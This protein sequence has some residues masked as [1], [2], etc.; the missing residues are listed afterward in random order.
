MAEILGSNRIILEL[1]RL[2]ILNIGFVWHALTFLKIPLPS[3]AI[4]TAKKAKVEILKIVLLIEYQS[5]LLEIV[6]QQKIP[7]QSTEG[8][9]L[10]SIHLQVNSIK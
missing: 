3:M 9:V 4:D 7:F 6:S 10:P 2:I 5:K 1:Q 8:M